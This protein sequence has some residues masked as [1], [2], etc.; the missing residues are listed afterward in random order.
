MLQ[1]RRNLNCKPGK[2][3]KGGY[4]VCASNDCYWRNKGCS[5]E[6]P[7]L[8]EKTIDETLLSFLSE[9]LSDKQYILAIVKHHIDSQQS[10]AQTNQISSEVTKENIKRL[11]G[12]LSRMEELY[13]DGG[14]SSPKE[15]LFKRKQTEDEL[16]KLREQS[17]QGKEATP[18]SFEPMVRRLITGALAIRRTKDRKVQQSVIRGLIASIT[19]CD[20]Q[21]LGYRLRPPVDVLFGEKDTRTDAGSDFADTYF[22]LP[23]PFELPSPRPRIVP[24][25]FKY[26]KMCQQ[27]LPYADFHPVSSTNPRPRPLCRICTRKM[28]RDGYRRGRNMKMK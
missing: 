20:A 4:Y 9:K 2:G 23:E 7:T 10:N 17:A 26:C 13:L 5:C 11:E 12:R 24:K 27:I 16:N 28:L 14:F 25:G 3:E 6:Q 18:E 21:I 15:Y 1:M 22:S 8:T 19:L